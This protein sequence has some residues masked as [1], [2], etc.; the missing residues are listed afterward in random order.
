[1]GNIVVSLPCTAYLLG[2]LITV[3]LSA[4]Q[5][6]KTCFKLRK[7]PDKKF[8]NRRLCTTINIIVIFACWKS[9]PQYCF[10]LLHFV[11]TPGWENYLSYLCLYTTTLP[12]TMQMTAIRLL[13]FCTSTMMKTMHMLLQTMSI[14]IFPLNLTMLVFYRQHLATTSRQALNL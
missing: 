4:S 6:K 10:Y 1:M 14:T 9:W 7:Q 12:T 5:Q 2:A 8:W 13:N 3:C 11:Q